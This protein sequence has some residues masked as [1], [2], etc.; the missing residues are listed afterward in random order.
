MKTRIKTT[1]IL[2]LALLWSCESTEENAPFD[3]PNE[4]EEM[5]EVMDYTAQV[6]SQV[7]VSNKARQ[8]VL[9]YAFDE[10]GGEVEAT[11]AE[12]LSGSTAGERSSVNGAEF[13]N[14][15][16]GFRPRAA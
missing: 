7:L 15:A 13:G 4:R 3:I 1:L 14:F 6:V 9:G 2:V 8:E 11:F 5:L 12:L 16:E 10:R